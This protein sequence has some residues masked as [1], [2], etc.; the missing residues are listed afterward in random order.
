M[1]QAL[2]SLGIP[3]SDDTP[4]FPIIIGSNEDTVEAS[5]LCEREGIILSGIRP[6]TVPVNTGRLRLTVTASHTEEELDKV[7]HVLQKIPTHK[8]I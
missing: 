1:H 3:S 7:I 5:R 2:Q 6:P 4:I 8:V